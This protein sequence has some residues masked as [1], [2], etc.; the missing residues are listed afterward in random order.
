MG[1]RFKILDK[2]WLSPVSLN[3]GPSVAMTQS[4]PSD[5]FVKSFLTAA[6]SSAAQLS[7]HAAAAAAV[8]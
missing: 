7:S 5:S 6:A 2:R 4:E 3:S 1:L 8:S